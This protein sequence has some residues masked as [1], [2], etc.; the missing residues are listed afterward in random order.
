MRNPN[1]SRLSVA[2]AL[3]G[4]LVLSGCGV[5]EITDAFSGGASMRIDVEVYKGPLSKNVEIQWGELTALIIEAQT[6]LATFDDDILRLASTQGYLFDGEL[7]HQSLDVWGNA[8]IAKIQNIEG[9]L[10]DADKALDEA[11]RLLTSTNPDIDQAQKSVGLAMDA[12]KIILFQAAHIT[13]IVSNDSR[14]LNAALASL[15]SGVEGLHKTL[16]TAATDLSRIDLSRLPDNQV[17]GV[18]KKEL[19]A[20]QGKLDASENDLTIAI[21]VTEDALKLNIIDL[22]DS[23]TAKVKRDLYGPLTVSP[24]Y[25]GNNAEG[26]RDIPSRSVSKIRGVDVRSRKENEIIWCRRPDYR[27]SLEGKNGSVWRA[28]VGRDCL[29]LAQLHD[30]IDHLQRMIRPFREAVKGGLADINKATL[31]DSALLNL[32][33]AVLGVK[34][35]K[36]DANTYKLVDFM[37]WA[38]RIGT[39]LKTKA[40]YWSGSMA[41]EAPG[42]PVRAMMTGFTNMAAELGNQIA[43][44]AD[45]ILKQCPFNKTEQKYKCD[46]QLARVLP[47]S[48]YL[49]EVNPTEFHNLATY[50]RSSGIA[51]TEEILS[52]PVWNL[53][54]EESTD[55]ARIVESLYADHNWSNINTVYASGQGDVN[56]AFIK[57][58]IGNWNL[59]NFKNDP[60]ELLEGY[61]KLTE[62]AVTATAKLAAQSAT[63]GASSGVSSALSLASRMMKGKVGPGGQNAAGIDVAVL[64]R[65]IERQI[66]DIT[67]MAEK[68]HKLIAEGKSTKSYKVEETDDYKAADEPNQKMKKQAENR[69]NVQKELIALLDYHDQMLASLQAAVVESSTQP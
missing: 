20:A 8:E 26:A 27:T 31:S 6:T 68:E 19:Q 24:H 61:S 12:H 38:S 16:N 25:R 62:A 48:V 37:E 2:T 51:T 49:R 47:L 40:F 13:R 60:T 3:A 41:A 45:T 56:M 22:G 69:E 17:E 1:Y 42:R 53:G 11:D 46:N 67:E 33:Q 59:K 63:G 5:T 57:D 66:N 50:N 55:R 35:S 21:D 29:L 32:E 34:I 10:N 54:T 65:A 23:I 36:N 52:R 4:S 64:S 7:P 30:E 14:G 58:S 44:R 9:Y 39:R 18:T 15:L 28:L 43:S